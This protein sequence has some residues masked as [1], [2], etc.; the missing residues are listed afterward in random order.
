MDKRRYFPEAQAKAGKEIIVIGEVNIGE[1]PVN[2]HYLSTKQKSDIQK[3]LRGWGVEDGDFNQMVLDFQRRYNS[4]L[5]RSASENAMWSQE[6]RFMVE[7]YHLVDL[8][9]AEAASARGSLAEG[10]EAQEAKSN[11]A[12]YVSAREYIGEPSVVRDLFA[13]DPALQME[14]VFPDGKSVRIGW[15]NH[16]YK[17]DFYRR[18]VHEEE[19]RLR[20]IIRDMEFKSYKTFAEA[21]NKRFSHRSDEAKQM[22]VADSEAVDSFNGRDIPHSNQAFENVRYAVQLWVAGDRV[23]VDNNSTIKV[24]SFVFESSDIFG[25]LPDLS[26]SQLI[27][28]GKKEAQLINTLLNGSLGAVPSV[29]AEFNRLVSMLNSSDY[30]D[31]G[32][33]S[34]ETKAE[35]NTLAEKYADF[36]PHAEALCGLR[37]VRSSE[38]MTHL[39]SHNPHILLWKQVRQLKASQ[40][41]SE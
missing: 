21:F 17:G 9:Y 35:I 39:G 30:I 18:G 16:F 8:A 29:S 33:Q 23:P 31:W 2:E 13:G 10:G 11:K 37:Y 32:E 27:I 12:R 7:V 36:E 38:I 4:E 22:L 41:M 6:V 14:Y 34:E 5:G 40:A 26:P 24:G 25:L 15:I 20:E 1:F 19:G 28:E 3:I